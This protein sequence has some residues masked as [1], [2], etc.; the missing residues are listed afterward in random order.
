MYELML[1]L[2]GVWGELPISYTCSSVSP[3]KVEYSY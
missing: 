2:Q 3:A 1:S